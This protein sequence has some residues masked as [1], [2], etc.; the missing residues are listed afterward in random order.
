[1]SQTGRCHLEPFGELCESVFFFF[2]FLITI[3][4]SLLE[5][6]SKNVVAY[7]RENINIVLCFIN[8]LTYTCFKVIAE[9]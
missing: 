9:K 5:K 3:I 1:M 8:E 7:S 4:L 2:F 6:L